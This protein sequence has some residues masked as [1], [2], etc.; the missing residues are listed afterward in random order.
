MAIH[1]FYKN[2]LISMGVLS[3]IAIALACAYRGYRT[4]NYNKA[5]SFMD[6]GD[7]RSAK[8][9]FE[10]LGTYKDCPSYILLISAI[11]S[12]QEEEYKDT[13]D[14]V[15]ELGDFPPAEAWTQR[16]K[17][18]Y[19]KQ[20]Y[21]QEDFKSAVEYFFQIE[22][23][24]D[25][26]N[27]LCQSM[28]DL[29]QQYYDSGEYTSA[30]SCYLDLVNRGYKGVQDGLNKSNLAYG[31][32]LFDSGNYIDAADVFSDLVAI[33][34]SAAQEWLMKTNYT[35]ALQLFGLGE[36]NN[37]LPIFLELDNYEMSAYYAEETLKLA[38]NISSDDLYAVAIRHFDKGLYWNALTEFEQLDD[39][40]NSKEYVQ[41]TKQMLRIALSSTISVGITH[42]VAIRTDNTPVSTLGDFSTDEWKNIVSIS[43]LGAITIGLKSDGTVITN[44]AAINAEVKT[45]ADVVAVSAGQAY[46]V[47]LRSDGTLVSAGHDAGDEQREVSDWTNIVAVATGWRHTVGLNREGTVLIT[48]YGSSRQLN[49]ISLN[50]EDWSNIVAVAAGGGSNTAP[51]AGHTVGLCSDGT[52]VAVGD[53]QYNQCDVTEWKDIVAIAAGDWFTIGLHSDGSVEITHPDAFKFPN[54]YMDAL[55]ASEWEDITAIAAGGGCVIGLHMDGTVDAAG[56]NDYNQTNA[57]KKWSDIMGYKNS[58]SNTLPQH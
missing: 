6:T 32:Q 25:S 48:G 49:Q 15:E 18:E 11:E 26:E 42:S 33:G 1:K 51:G 22:G 39:Y 19:G 56:Y 9:Y 7:Y 41:K 31:K 36:Y 3:A 40:K 44:S 45:W 35:Y 58:G 50:K 17:Y 12:F 8:N 21:A 47:G 43:T 13:I 57:A 46:V 38:D 55:N 30:I 53:N 5:V 4:Y 2:V 37:A 23:Y 14:V 54:L 34:Y 29:A 28:F 16:A 24:K 27:L 20:L 10:K 52:V